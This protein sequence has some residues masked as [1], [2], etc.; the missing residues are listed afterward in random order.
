MENNLDNKAR[1]FALYYGQK[2]LCIRK[3]NEPKL[4]VGFDDFTPKEKLQTDYLEL[5]PLSSI[6]D[7]DALPLA[8]AFAPLEIIKEAKIDRSRHHYTLIRVS[9]GNWPT[10]KYTT[11]SEYLDHTP[12][13]SVCSD[14]L[15]S[16][17]YALPFM[18]LSVEKQ[19]EY[20]W[21]KLTL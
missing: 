21:I 10:S 8:K 11:K 17:G 19:I 5:K 16:K 18:G 1:F 20:N 15:R 2:V 3:S 4:Y 9:R 7:E 14:Y 13:Y 12:A 6:T